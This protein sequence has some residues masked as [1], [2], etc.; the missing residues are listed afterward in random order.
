MINGP[1]FL[2]KMEP[3]NLPVLYVGVSQGSPFLD[4]RVACISV[5]PHNEFSFVKIFTYLTKGNME[6]EG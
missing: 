2:L 3:E 5:L 4:P 1:S 6:I